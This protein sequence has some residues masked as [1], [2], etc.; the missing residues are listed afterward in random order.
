MPIYYRTLNTHKFLDSIIITMNFIAVLLC[1]YIFIVGVSKKRRTRPSLN[2]IIIV[3]FS[4]VVLLFSTLSLFEKIK[5][6]GLKNGFDLIIL[7]TIAVYIVLLMMAL[8]KNILDR[9]SLFISSTLGVG[10]YLIIFLF[11]SLIIGLSL[12]FTNIEIYLIIKP[13]NLFYDIWSTIFY[14]LKYSLIG[15]QY[16]FNLPSIVN[17]P[18]NQFDIN[19]TNLIL[20]YLIYIIGLCIN[21]IFIAY[22]VSHAGTMYNMRFSQPNENNNYVFRKTVIG[23]YFQFLKIKAKSTFRIIYKRHFKKP[24]YLLSVHY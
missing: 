12:S 22:L 4:M 13:T 14:Y 20:Q 6:N 19:S 23:Y 18:S 17:N 7:M 2:A 16:L 8:L 11:I 15:A 10:L 3:I 5:A 1:I 21:I 9:E 24:N